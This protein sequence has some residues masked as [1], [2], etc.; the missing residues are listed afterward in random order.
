[1]S[2]MSSNFLRI[3][4]PIFILFISITGFG[5]HWVWKSGYQSQLN[6]QRSQIEQYASYILTKLD[7][8]AHIPRLLSKDQRLIKALQN[9]NNPAQA[10]LTN[11]YLE[12]VNKLIRASDTY[13]LDREGNTVA[14]SNWNQE[15]SFIGRNFSWR[16][17]FQK[18]VQ[19]EESH[20]Y[21]LGSTS[22]KRGY[23]YSYPIIYAG[24]ILGVVVV[25]MDL[26]AIEEH[27]EDKTSYFI[28]T[29]PNQIIF[30]SSQPEWLFKS[31]TPLTLRTQLKLHHSKQYLD[32]PIRSLNL[33]GDF[34]ATTTE[35]FDP[36]RIWISGDYLV[37]SRHLDNIPLTIRVISPKITIFWNSFG[38]ILITI[39][40]FTILYLSG[41]LIL[42]RKSRQK[43]FDQIQHEAKQKLEFQ[44]MERTAKLNTEIEERKKTEQQLIQ[45]QNELIQAAK[46]AV[47]GQMSASISHEL[48]NPLAA[49]RSFADNGRR[50][51]SSGKP[52][53]ADEN[54]ARIASLTERMAKISTQ[55]RSFSRKT[56]QDEFVVAQIF[57]II[58]SIKELIQSQLKAHQIHLELNPPEEP[59]WLNVN[60]IQLEQ[61]LLNLLTNAIQA[62]AEQPQKQ[63]NIAVATYQAQLYLHIDDNGDGLDEINLTKLF[64]P[65]YTTRKN[66]LGLGLS[67]S[68]QIIQNMNGHIEATRSP[69]GGARFT[70]V[71]PTVPAPV[72]ESTS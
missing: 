50:F 14:A 47:L 61:V 44:V 59:I 55:L 42:H 22:G 17:Y 10:D 25:K 54:L 11:R 65:F 58:L 71:L 18:A 63:I 69:F 8:F 5:A 6:E 43:Q 41:L 72:T 31:V 1:M 46:L 36:S 48:N 20:Y 62:L 23:Y 12:E 32:K 39:M 66:G 33:T 49:I 16:P 29:D 4:L 68:Q 70:I 13:L 53:R 57:P 9:T 21:A 37:T 64:D 40:L 35:W 38:F 67:I 52:E 28:A 15:L 56:D 60:P 27:W 7:K 30:M 19:G 2:I 3:H 34:K 45:T 26:S 51:I 24:D